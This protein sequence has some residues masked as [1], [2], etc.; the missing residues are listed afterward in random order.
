MDFDSPPRKVIQGIPLFLA[1]VSA[2]NTSVGRKLESKLIATKDSPG[3]I[4]LYLKLKPVL[5]KGGLRLLD[6]FFSMRKG[7]LK[8]P[9]NSFC[10]INNPFEF[11]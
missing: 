9:H 10:S 7:I 8:E 11:E 3:I 1:E 4:P 5:K 6:I 2:L